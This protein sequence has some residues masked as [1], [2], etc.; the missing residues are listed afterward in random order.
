MGTKT[1]T[2]TNMK[3]EK[4]IEFYFEM[5]Q[6]YS[7]IKTVLRSRNGFVSWDLAKVSQDLANVS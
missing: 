5:G 1:K 3:W 2:G 7:K 4:C 6:K